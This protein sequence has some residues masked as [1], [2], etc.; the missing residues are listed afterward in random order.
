[1]RQHEIA[2]RVFNNYLDKVNKCTTAWDN[3]R[4]DTDRVISLY[5]RDYA[6]L[7]S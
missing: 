4:D 6:Y 7:I 1:M 2:N 3:F 5:S